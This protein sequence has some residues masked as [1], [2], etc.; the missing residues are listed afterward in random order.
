M[1]KGF[2]DIWDIPT[3]IVAGLL[4]TALLVFILRLVF[5]DMIVGW[6]KFEVPVNRPLTKTDVELKKD[7]I[8][9][10]DKISGQVRWDDNPSESK[11]G[12]A[13]AMWHPADVETKR[14]FP[15]SDWPAGCLFARIGD[16][17]Y[18]LSSAQY[19]G[20]RFSADN[21]GTLSFSLNDDDFNDNEG[22]FAVKIRLI[23]GYDASWAVVIGIDQYENWPSLQYAVNGAKA[24]REKLLA[25]G[26]PKENIFF[27][28]DAQATK[29]RIEWVLG[30]ELPR[31]AGQNDRVFL[32]FAGHGQTEGLPGHDQE[33][34]IVPVDGDKSNL[35]ST[36]ISMKTLR[37]FSDRIAA[38]HM[39]YA[40]DACYSGL[41]LVPGEELDPKDRRYLQKVARLPARQ[42]VT[43][44]SAGEGVIERDGYGAF[45]K[46]LLTALDGGADRF[47]PFGVLTGSELGIY[48]K[49][50]VSV[51]TN[52]AETPL[53]GRLSAG[54]GEFMFLLEGGITERT[55]AEERVSSKVATAKWEAGPLREPLEPER[56]RTESGKARVEG[57]RLRQESEQGKK[58]DA[59]V[60]T[61]SGATLPDSATME[62]PEELVHTARH[63]DLNAEDPSIEDEA[64]EI[65]PMTGSPDLPKPDT[66]ALVST[67][68]NV[69]PPLPST[70]PV[71]KVSEQGPAIL[72]PLAAA[73][74]FGIEVNDGL[75][76]MEIII[77]MSGRHGY[78]AFLLSNPDRL[79]VD[80]EPAVLIGKR[81][82]L[83]VNR[84]AIQRVR[85]AQFENEPSIVR[86]VVDLRTKTDYEIV[87]R[88]G[89]TVI[90]IQSRN[91][92]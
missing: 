73:N 38:K 46:A 7:D 33:G 58:S 47:P 40:M 44:G 60:H 51:E 23:R 16:R 66:A 81:R 87:K 14:K 62:K 17:D 77:K 65:V 57:E 54:K 88:G 26:F 4:L 91:L 71:Q 49:T 68:R 3:K 75:S 28:I 89:H 76:G 63:G 86:V 35:L 80:I 64:D 69:V 74:C 27:L 25:L 6:R 56:V 42:L 92:R 53:F 8:I 50:V 48:L 5:A 72:A 2:D 82:T 55:S 90:L 21:S 43:A 24:A 36:C 84:R 15:H 37:Q 22:V 13:G 31:M 1:T 52:N 11:I 83:D 34:Y 45:T 70:M 85:I 79:A 12:P 39:F 78:R 30:D 9:V 41:A 18:N 59:R 10:V 32:Y 61:S 20:M 67:E 19:T 29:D